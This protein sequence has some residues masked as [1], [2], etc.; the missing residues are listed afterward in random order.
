MNKEEKKKKS[1]ECGT[2]VGTL[3]LPVSFGVRLPVDM[4]VAMLV[5]SPISL[6]LVWFPQVL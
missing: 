1:W 5:N 4:P 3:F 2:G 6:F